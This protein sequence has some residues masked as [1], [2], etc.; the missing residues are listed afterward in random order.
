[1]PLLGFALAKA[2][3]FEPSIAVG[4]ILLGA[5]PGGV[6]SNVMTY[7]AKGDVALSVTLTACSTVIAPVVTPLYM[8]LLAGTLVEI[9]FM[10]W[11]IDIFRVIVL[12]IVIGLIVNRL[13]LAMKWRGAWVD[14]CLS[15]IA[16]AGICL[17]IAIIIA[18][19][20][21]KLMKVGIPLVAA[22]IIHNLAGYVLGYYGAWLAKL[23]ESSCRT[24]AIEVGLQNGG[25]ATA[26]AINTLKDPLAALAPAIFGP[27]MNISGSLLASWWGARELKNPRT[28]PPES[29]SE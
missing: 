4:V 1:M 16:M 18:D 11:V 26:L 6:A 3:A 21:N 5:C 20:R 10:D 14:R 29:T 25:M 13:L 24:V 23:D 17:I 22:A 15:L 19:S 7:L 28:P 9:V 12:P 27:W 2:F 8:S